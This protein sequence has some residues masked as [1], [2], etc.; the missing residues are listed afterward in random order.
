VRVKKVR[1]IGGTA[2][3]IDWKPQSCAKELCAGKQCVEA[4][5]AGEKSH[6]V[7]LIQV[8]AG[9]ISTEEIAYD[10]L[11]EI[12]PEVK[13]LSDEELVYL[14]VGAFSPGL[15]S[16]SVIG[17]AGKSVA[18]AAGESTG[19]L[20]SK[21]IKPLVMAD[22]PA[23]LRLS[24]DYTKDEKGVHALG[25][26][27]PETVLELLPK[28]IVAILRRIGSK[29]K[30][31]AAIL[32]QY[33]TAIPIGTAIA[34]SWNQKLAY[35]C[36]E[37]VGA[38]MERFGVHLWLAPALNIHRDIRC[39]R[40]FEYFSEDPL[41]SGMFAAEM[42]KAVQA[43]PGCGVTIKHFAANNQ[44]TNRYVNNSIVSERAL[45]E[46]YLRGFGICIREAKPYALMTSYNLLNGVHT[47]ERQDLIEDYLRSECGHQGIV[48]TDW[49]IGGGFLTQKSKYP[50]ANALRIAKA[51]GDIIMPGSSGDYKVILNGLKTGEITREQLEQNA[52]RVLHVRKSVV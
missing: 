11:Q 15:G 52:T 19:K 44:E 41:L 51:G 31:N 22:G 1:H 18:G 34:Q 5:H 27:L 48:M 24:R 32:H 49:L 16:L 21:G 8:T 38:E 10:T 13:A 30:K 9:E 25:E 45:R 2:D 7:P 6:A 23:G 35:Q 39:G 42:T 14:N 37:I 3:F 17:N 20:R 12:A 29:P 46:I 47:S 36:G 4:L 26:S 50:V 33:T 28:P 40:N 43:H